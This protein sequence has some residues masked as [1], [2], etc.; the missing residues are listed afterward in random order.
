MFSS[1]FVKNKKNEKLA[2]LIDVG[3]A[4]VGVALVEVSGSTPPRIY[5]SSRED[6]M[7]QDKL[8]PA[9]LMRAMN[10]ALEGSLKAIQLSTKTTGVPSHIFCSLSSPWFLSKNKHIVIEQKEAFEVTP[11]VLE[12]FLD[13]EIDRVQEELKDTLPQ[14]DVRIIEKKIIRTKLN[15]YEINN[16]YGQKAS[17]VELALTVGISSKQ[18]TERIEHTISNFFHSNV[19]HFGAFPIAAFNTIRDIFPTE[20]SFLFL[21]ITGEGTDISFVNNN[22]LVDTVA[23]TRGKNFFIREISSQF[24]MPHQVA[25][26][27]LNMFL[28]GTLDDKRKKEIELFIS[29]IEND[30]VAR[31]GK[32]VAS[33]NMSE[34]VA[35]KI[36]FMADPDVIV[37]FERIL[38]KIPRVPAGKEYF[39]IQRL[40]SLTFGKFVSFENGV[41]R[42]PF[43]IVEALLAAK[44]VPQL[45][46]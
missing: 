26:S 12:K 28:G 40:D 17:R 25:T 39:E 4:S 21:D 34:S 29:K 18:A 37:L 8:T 35:H 13:E 1:F 2:L 14:Q 33:L 41:T 42:D 32:A 11:A 23:F 24:R 38:S 22:I 36:F 31:F 7:L 20:R 30:W 27:V 46:K 43:L 10:Q 15:G 45:K 44:I 19:V 6:M 5:A 9:Q 16:P 3:S